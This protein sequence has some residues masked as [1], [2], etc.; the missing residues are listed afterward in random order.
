MSV[1]HDVLIRFNNIFKKEDDFYR[2]AARLL[3]CSDCEFW[4]LYTLCLSN[5]PLTQ[6]ELCDMQ[7]QPKQTV[8]SSLKKLE[9]DG[10]LTLIHK[11]NRRS[12]YIE[13]TPLGEK[14][15]ANTA[16]QVI[17]IEL[18]TFATFS[19]EEQETFLQLYERY[20]D[21]LKNNIQQIQPYRKE[22]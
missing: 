5:H 16:Q 7:Y 18:E 8:N 12:K 19:K 17:H 11:N 15:A 6:S 13:L 3:G 1:G 14:L 9:A 4:I 21:T 10:Y 20:A 22:L 2:N